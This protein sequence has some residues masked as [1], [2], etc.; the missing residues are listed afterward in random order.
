MYY[1]KLSERLDFNY[2]KKGKEIAFCTQ[3]YAILEARKPIAIKMAKKLHQKMKHLPFHLQ[4]PC[5]TVFLLVEEL[6]KC[7]R[8]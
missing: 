4:N 6:D 3:L 2:E 8:K 1:E 5:T 7:L